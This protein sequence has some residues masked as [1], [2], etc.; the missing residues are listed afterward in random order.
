MKKKL[1]KQLSIEETR[2]LIKSAGFCDLDIRNTIADL[3]KGI[4]CRGDILEIPSSLL[5]KAEKAKM[6]FGLDTHY[7]LGDV[8]LE[9]H[10]HLA[11]TF[12]NQLIVEHNCKTVDEKALAE[13]VAMAFARILVYTKA[14]SGGLELSI[15]AKRD[16][17]FYEIA[18][19]ELD[20]ANRQFLTGITTL[21]QLKSPPIELNINTKNAFISQNQQINTNK[22]ENQ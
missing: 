22:I 11:T 12:A 2:E 20:R 6:A 17:R 18:S 5:D 9:K 7:F 10:A 19:K 8:L 15:Y 4:I 21:R 14:L 3:S 1:Q 13:V 16:D